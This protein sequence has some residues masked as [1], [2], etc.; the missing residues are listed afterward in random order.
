GGGHI[1]AKANRDYSYRMNR[2]AVKAA[3]K[4]AIAGKIAGEQVVVVDDLNFDEIKTRQ[5]VDLLN[6]LSLGGKTALIA[7][8]SVNRVVYRSARNIPGVEVLPACD[9]NALAVLRPDCV[10]VSKAAMDQLRGGKAE[11]SAA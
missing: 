6:A 11:E 8:E 7:T 9:L 5:V 3:T 1:H 10:L 4:M 2:K